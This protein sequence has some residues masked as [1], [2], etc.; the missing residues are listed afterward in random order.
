MQPHER[1][2][3]TGPHQ[4]GLP[5]RLYLLVSLWPLQW[6]QGAYGGSLSD[7]NAARDMGDSP[8]VPIIQLTPC[9]TEKT[10]LAH[11]AAGGS[12]ATRTLSTDNPGLPVLRSPP[13][14]PGR[15]G[16]GGV[17]PGVGDTD[18]SLR[19]TKRQIPPSLPRGYTY[20]NLSTIKAILIHDPGS[21][22]TRKW[23]ERWRGGVGRL[24]CLLR[25]EGAGCQPCPWDWHFNKR[26]LQCPVLV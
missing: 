24:R 22:R 4:G 15:E 20:I 23:W 13:G 2:E 8:T 5:W 7:P 21:K 25:R 19:R 12:I 17:G 16:V 14:L 18:C 6:T 26:L 1:R 9:E 3:E 11:R 10:R